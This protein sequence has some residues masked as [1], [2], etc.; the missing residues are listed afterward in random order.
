[1]DE[2]RAIVAR[3]GVE[4]EILAAAEGMTLLV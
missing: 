3:S 1:V 2:C 4:L